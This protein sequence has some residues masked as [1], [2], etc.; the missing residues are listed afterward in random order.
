MAVNPCAPL[1]RRIAR[2]RADDGMAA[3][4]DDASA[5]RASINK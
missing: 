5:T 1:R 2:L 3:S 4:P